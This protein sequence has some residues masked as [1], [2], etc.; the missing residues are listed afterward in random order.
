M[1][2]ATVARGHTVEIPDENAEKQIAGY[3]MI[4][5]KY[6]YRQPTRRYGPG[7]TVTLPQSEVSRLTGLGFLVDPTST[8]IAVSTTGMPLS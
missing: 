5:Q 1:M 7:A 4:D 2:E 8:E 6:I 3:S